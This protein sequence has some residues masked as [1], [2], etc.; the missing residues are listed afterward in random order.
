MYGPG[1]GIYS[2]TLY[3]FL[4]GALLPVPFYLLVRMGYT[5]FRR[6]Y[7]PSLLFGGVLW[8]PLNF[9]WV[10]NGL[11]IGSYFQLYLKRRFFSWWAKY[12]VI[13]YSEL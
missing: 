1:K 2:V 4:V 12:N 6:I 8:A 10:I 11:Y 9:S 5:R 13:P 3:G 7:A